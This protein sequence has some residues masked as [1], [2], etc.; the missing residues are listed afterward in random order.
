MGRRGGVEPTTFDARSADSRSRDRG[1]LVGLSQWSSEDEDG[2]EEE[3][4]GRAR[5]RAGGSRRRARAER[6]GEAYGTR[7]RSA[8][9]RSETFEEED[10]AIEITRAELE[11]LRD[12]IDQA[13][14]DAGYSSSSRH[15]SRAGSRSSSRHSSR[16]GGFGASV[17]SVD[18]DFAD[19][20]STTV[21]ESVD[22]GGM[23]VMNV[24]A[25]LY[26]ALGGEKKPIW[27]LDEMDDEAT[28]RSRNA[29]NIGS[30][31]VP[32][33]IVE[34]Y[35]KAKKDYEEAVKAKRV[36]KERLR[37]EAAA[38]A[39]KEKTPSRMDELAQEFRRAIHNEDAALEYHK[40]RQR[41]DYKNASATRK[42]AARIAKNAKRPPTFYEGLLRA[43]FGCCLG[44]R[45]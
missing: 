36:K 4:R 23:N 33:K 13:R 1:S 14:S 37:R 26:A 34:K 35:D 32:H 43:M 7:S 6:L 39:A 30:A 28:K 3:R 18:P 11:K 22:N 29:H 40:V 10:E 44:A 12:R 15:S 17:E 5:S 25:D 42:R 38:E 21:D 20:K 16:R 27:T 2:V 8:S 24:G 19:E 45:R 9:K 31:L 41:M